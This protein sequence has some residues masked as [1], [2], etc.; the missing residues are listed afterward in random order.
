MEEKL[1]GIAKEIANFMGMIITKRVYVAIAGKEGKLYYKDSALDIYADL[2]NSFMRTSF[3]LLKLGDHALPISSLP[4]MFFKTSPQT[5]I[6]LYSRE[7]NIKPGQL[8]AFK[9]KSF[10]Y[11]EKIVD[12]LKEGLKQEFDEG[13]ISLIEFK[14]PEETG[15]PEPS[16]EPEE[17]GTDYQ[18]K[19]VPYLLKEIKKKDKFEIG[20]SIVLNLIEQDNSIEEIV[21]KSNLSR[22]TVEE[23]I[24]K[25]T[26]RG[27]LGIKIVEPEIKIGDKVKIYPKLTELI[28]LTFKISDDERAVLEH[29][30]GYASIDNIIEDTKLDESVVLEVLDAWED[31]G[32]L[33]FSSDSELIY[34]PKNIKKLNPMGVQ[35]GLMTRKEYKIRELCTGDVTAPSIAKTLDMDYKELI[36]ILKKMEKKGDIKLKVKKR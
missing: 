28:A 8:L 11:T 1:E 10:Q 34:I 19:V 15:K 5:A 14:V 20:E 30:T 33:D 13:K 27:W 9:G 18:I 36:A 2:L 26:E 31:K 22:E 29:C 12:V 4:L 32:Q 25:F 3:D 17:A 6:I 16:K 35:L 23:I 7:E 21:E 24:K